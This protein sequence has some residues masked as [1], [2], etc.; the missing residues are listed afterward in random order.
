MPL[1]LTFLTCENGGVCYLFEFVLFFSCP[2]TDFLLQKLF[3]FLE[4][5][6]PSALDK[7]SISEGTNS[8]QINEHTIFTVRPVK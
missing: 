4:E 7:E 6:F 5:H 3:R 2:S 1:C 8:C